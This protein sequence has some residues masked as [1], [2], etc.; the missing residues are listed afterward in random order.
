ME[1]LI[2]TLFIDG[3]ILIMLALGGISLVMGLLYTLTEWIRK[4]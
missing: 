4:K 2:Y 3:V 1:Q